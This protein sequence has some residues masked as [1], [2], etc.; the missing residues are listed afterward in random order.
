MSMNVQGS[1]QT[2]VLRKAMD[3][4]KAAADLLAKTVEG[5]QQVQAASL[6]TTSRPVATVA[7]GSGV[8]GNLD[9]YA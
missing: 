7:A 6:A 9:L 2:S 4:P 1:I 8:G 3:Q 5:L